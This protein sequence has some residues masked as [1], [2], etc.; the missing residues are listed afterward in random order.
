MGDQKDNKSLIFSLLSFG[1]DQRGFFDS[2]GLAG[3]GM[4]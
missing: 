4:I 2:E 1:L 3:L